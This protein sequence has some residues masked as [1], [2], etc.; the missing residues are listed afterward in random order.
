MKTSRLIIAILILCSFLMGCAHPLIKKLDESSNRISSLAQT[1][2]NNFD[3]CL[4][5]KDK[6]VGNLSVCDEVEAN[7]L[8]IINASN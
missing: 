7:L 3:E 6:K 2:K 4:I 1:A 5:Q 8:A